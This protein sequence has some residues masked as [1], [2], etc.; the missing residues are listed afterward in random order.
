[1][2][3]TYS[4]KF[5]AEAL[6]I[7][8]R[9]WNKRA[10]KLYVPCQQRGK[11]GSKL[12]LLP[13]LPEDVQ[14]AI[15]KHEEKEILENVAAPYT[16]P[17]AKVEEKPLK[18]WQRDV[19]DARLAILDAVKQLSFP[20]GGILK[21]EK[22]FENK[23]KAGE[24]SEFLRLCV[25]RANARAGKKRAVTAAS[26]RLWRRILK[27]EGA[28]GLAPKPPRNQE[29]PIPTWLAPFTQL[30][31]QPGKPS[32][33]SCYEKLAE[34]G[35]ALPV[36]RTVERAIKRMVGVVELS[37]GRLGPR[38]FKKMKAYCKRKF[39]FL[40]PGD[41]YSADGH[42][43]D[44]TV[45]HP[46]HGQPVRPE[47][48]SVIDVATRR[49]VGWS[50]ELFESSLLV[51]D[52][53]RCSVE[54]AGIPAI[55]YVDNGCGFKNDLLNGPGHGML[56]RLGT[57]I[58]H[59]LPYNSQARGVIEGFNKTCWIKA[60]R[61]ESA[62]CG[63]DM[64]QDIRKQRDKRIKQDIAETG[65]SA[66]IMSWQQFTTWVRATI[67][68]YNNRA[69]SGLPKI[70]DPATG[71][72]RHQTPNERWAGLAPDAEII[73]PTEKEL[74]D[75]FRPYRV[76]MVR[77]CVVSL[78]D[79]EYYSPA[80]DFYHGQEV[81]VGYDIHNASQV[82]IRDLEGTFICVAGF[83]R[84]ARDYFPKPFIEEAREQRSAQQVKRLKKKEAK[85]LEQA[86]PAIEAAPQ[87]VV[88]DLRTRREQEAFF[89]EVEAEERQ[90]ELAARQPSEKKRRILRAL[91]I[92]R[93]LAAGG[94]VNDMDAKWFETYAR[95]PEYV[96]A[97]EMI[98]AFGEEMGLA[99][100]G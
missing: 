42:C 19:R 87:A 9:A 25:A 57:R 59:S 24:L 65:H 78:W 5:I 91:E 20:L 63:M 86:K 29:E 67:D 62:Y 89:K 40:L 68:A 23:A 37:R 52:A 35:V 32:I 27:E 95:Q 26:L 2:R 84:N 80:L 51:A 75:I 48:I 15:R 83:E 30:Y 6:G 97:K 45:Q 98:D 7:S 4:S 34:Q 72:K 22:E 69:H 64:A 38:E 18:D 21:A 74:A 1:M 50:A 77:R 11:S 81:Q 12:Y 76:R 10:V 99:S 66:H 28:D 44:L 43:M 96:S 16:L 79:N 82:W 41:V 71:K 60:A 92:E 90:K 88:I 73:Q 55:F 61:L 39:D 53:I 93:R 3:E 33:N 8:L 13:S 85:I 100:F 54:W 17:S 14:T 36:K 94:T 49:C 56:L 58:S 31:C 47:I 46:E 70:S